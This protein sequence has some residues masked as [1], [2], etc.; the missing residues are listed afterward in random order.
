MEKMEAAETLQTL[1]ASHLGILAL[2]NEGESYAI[3]LYFGF[4]GQDVFFQCHPG[5]KDEYVD[6]TDRACLV[7]S[8]VAGPNIWESIQVFGPV[9]RMYINSDVDKA[10]HALFHVPF[11]PAEGNYPKGLPVRSENHVYYLRL[12]PVIIEGKKSS[13]KQ[14]LQ[15]RK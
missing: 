1:E 12:R 9:E 6:A 11:P 3:P 4:D 13:I 10:K 15:A 8:H 14:T 7:V 2:S 5:L